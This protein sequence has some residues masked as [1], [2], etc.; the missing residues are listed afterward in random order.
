MFQVDRQVSSVM[1]HT[2]GH[3]LG[4][5]HSDKSSAIMLSLGST[6]YITT[7]S[8]DEKIALKFL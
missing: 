3:V 2:I 4:L 5:S 7:L 8:S 6:T 1:V